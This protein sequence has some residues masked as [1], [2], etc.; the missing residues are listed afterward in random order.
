MDINL[1]AETI[2]NTDVKTL[3]AASLF[4]WNI[5]RLVSKVR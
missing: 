3:I 2:L 5:T 1:L 4:I